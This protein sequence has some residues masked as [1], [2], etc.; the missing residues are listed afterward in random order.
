MDNT[1]GNIYYIRKI[2]ADLEFL[3]KHTREI[4]YKE[5]AENEILIDSIMFRLIQI[6][7]NSAKLSDDFKARCNQIPWRAIKGLRN[8][9]VHEY[10]KVD[11]TVIYDTVK[12]DIPKLFDLLIDV[13]NTDSA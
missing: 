7:E 2:I 10:G 5:L 11:L 8:R 6:S 12:N 4:S 9:I 3:I 13:V 1:K